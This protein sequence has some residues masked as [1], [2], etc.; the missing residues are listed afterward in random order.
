MRYI[1][2]PDFHDGHI[3]TVSLLG[4]TAT[5]VAR[6][7]GGSHYTLSFKGVVSTKINSPEGMILYAVAEADCQIPNLR[8][9]VFI[10]WYVDDPERDEA[11][12]SLEVVAENVS[13][14]PR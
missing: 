7:S 3:E 8:R 10:N 1:G 6:G 13:I 12:S 14:A 4:S 2:Y 11:N 5:V 9:Y